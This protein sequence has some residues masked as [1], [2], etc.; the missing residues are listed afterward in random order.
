MKREREMV[1]PFTSEFL[2]L[3]LSQTLKSEYIKHTSGPVDKGRWNVHMRSFL[4]CLFS[5][6]FMIK[7]RIHYIQHLIY[8][9]KK[10]R[11]RTFFFRKTIWRAKRRWKDNIKI[12]LKEVAWTVVAKVTV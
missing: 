6:V 11:M 9:E 5:L 4:I 3:L 12:Y 10:T 8:K 2:Y 7:S 1:I